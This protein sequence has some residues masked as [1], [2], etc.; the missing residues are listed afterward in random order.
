LDFVTDGNAV[1]DD[2]QRRGCELLRRHL[3]LAE[4]D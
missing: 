3:G 4:V 1:T 2:Q